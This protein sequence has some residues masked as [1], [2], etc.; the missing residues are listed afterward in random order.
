MT[1]G[2]PCCLWHELVCDGGLAVIS[3]YEK[4]NGGLS[5]R[6]VQAL[7]QVL[8]GLTRYVRS[9]PIEARSFL[10]FEPADWDNHLILI[11]GLLSNQVT[12]ALTQEQ[13]RKTQGSLIVRREMIRDMRH[14]VGK[15]C[16]TPIYEPNLETNVS[17]TTVDY[18]SITIQP[19]PM[20]RAK[21]LYLLAGIKGWGTLAAAA[22]FSQ[23]DY[24]L[25]LNQLFVEH[26][27][28]STAEIERCSLIEIIVR[29]EI[30]CI[31]G[32][33]GIKGVRNLSIELVRVNG[34]VQTQWIPAETKLRWGPKP[35][36]TDQ[37]EDIRFPSHLSLSIND[38]VATAELHGAAFAAQF[39]QSALTQ[40]DIDRFDY[41]V[42]AALGSSDWRS[43]ARSI[44]D[45]LAE[46]L[47]SGFAD[48]L[49]RM[50]N[51]HTRPEHS[52]VRFITP[53]EYLRLPFEFLRSERGYLALEY[54]IV[55]SIS[56]VFTDRPGLS[57]AFIENLKIRQL[58]LRVLLIAA[59]PIG[60]IKADVS[61]EVERI[62]TIFNQAEST[63]NI[64]I[65]ISII[66]PEDATV[67]QIRRVL[68]NGAYHILHFA[69]HSIWNKP[70]PEQSALYVLDD[71]NQPTTLSAVQITAWV[72]HSALRFC[73][74]SS[75]EG[76]RSAKYQQLRDE[77]FGLAD[78][79]AQ[80]GV[81]EILGFR[82]PVLSIGALSFAES[83]YTALLG[84]AEFNTERALLHARQNIGQDLDDLMWLLPIL[85]SQK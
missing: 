52:S 57:P 74:L 61:Q 34:D 24:Y 66:F 63:L 84:Q 44:A 6:D 33:Q 59:D 83:F 81:P 71:N 2:V 38:R 15:D 9:N 36:T 39:D 76:A 14:P 26:F 7:A 4:Y 73:Y 55:R 54:P 16:I 67:S 28:M 72:R 43:G 32:T 1:E 51:L 77:F 45:R 70:T 27:G 29:T 23:P 25:A 21:R 56:D 40:R 17:G 3:T 82:W 62:A 11:G 8:T 5:P 80:A 19:N 31:G 64:Q 12:R 37:L 47:P 41:D 42:E 49:Q 18:G 50:Q 75:C 53:R 22:V 13:I 35:A 78:A 85:I 20:N 69:G 46:K 10:A 68:Q 65:D 79:L 60:N 48:L 58:P 30:G